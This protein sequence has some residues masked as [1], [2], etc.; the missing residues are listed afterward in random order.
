[1]DLPSVAEVQ[2]GLT[3]PR[4]ICPRLKSRGSASPTP[5]GNFK[6]DTGRRYLPF[7]AALASIIKLEGD[8]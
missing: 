4:D 3:S 1:M 7:P 6:S 5:F 8:T 2:N